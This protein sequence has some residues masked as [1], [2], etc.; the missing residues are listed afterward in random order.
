M[1]CHVR[2]TGHDAFTWDIVGEKPGFNEGIMTVML[3]EPFLFLNVR[4]QIAQGIEDLACFLRFSLARQK[5]WD[6]S[7]DLGRDL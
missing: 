2:R 7:L 1:R 5:L 4:G 6:V 3:S